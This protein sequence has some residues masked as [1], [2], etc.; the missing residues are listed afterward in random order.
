MRHKRH[1]KHLATRVAHAGFGSLLHDFNLL[2]HLPYRVFRKRDAFA[3]AS[4]DGRA[5]CRTLEELGP[6]FVEAGR[7]VASRN[8]IIPRP[9]QNA[10]LN[11]HAALPAMDPA[12]FTKLLR[13]AIGR[14]SMD[15]IA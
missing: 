9:F 6:G 5:L 3:H 10:L 2:H 4:A 12:T 14:G 13:H 15:A 1:L 7:I 11:S 8:D